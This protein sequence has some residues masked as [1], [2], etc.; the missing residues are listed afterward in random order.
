MA[1][2]LPTATVATGTPGGIITVES[3]ESIPP[4]PPDS[5]GIPITGRTV[6]AANAP[7]K[8]AAMPAAAIN[9]LQPLFSE[10][11]I[12]SITSCGVLCADIT[13]LV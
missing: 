9:T 2:L 1:P 11:F 5:I 12:N 4:I 13:F 10:F 7:A 3:K 6:C 8:C